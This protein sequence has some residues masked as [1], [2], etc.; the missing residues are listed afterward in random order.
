MFLVTGAGGQ[1]GSE[2][3]LLLGEEA[4]YVGHGELDITDEE[5]VKAFFA[6]NSFD[7]VINCAAYTAVD[8]AEDD[9]EA[10]EKVNSLGPLYLARYGRRIVQISTDY[11]FDGTSCRPYT[12]KDAPNPVSVYGRTKLA[13]E[14]AVLAGAECAVVIRTS[15]LYSSFGANFV[16]TMRR[17]GAE[18]ESLGVVFDQAGTP[19]YA[20]DLAAAIVSMLPQI[21]PGMKEVYHF[22]NEGVT[23]WY[24]FAVAIMEESH[25]AC[26]VRPIE[27]SAYPTRAVR[28]AYS[29]LN[30]AKIRQDFG[31]TIPH[32]RDGLKRCVRIIEN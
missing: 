19:T 3:R 8:K 2:L 30:K 31:L 20:A 22:S 26:A 27:S 1:L 9:T 12:E 28:P 7:F 15:W 16:K 25:L 17:L 5:A 32:W 24:D 21:R 11:V 29:V 23:S 14:N 4:V 18:R 13:G 6:G 10:A